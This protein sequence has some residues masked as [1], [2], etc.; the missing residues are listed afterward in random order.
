LISFVMTCRSQ[1]GNVFVI[2]KRRMLLVIMCIANSLLVHLGCQV[3]HVEPKPGTNGYPVILG[4][5]TK[6]FKFRHNVWKR[7]GDRANRVRF[8]KISRGSFR[9]ACRELSGQSCST[10]YNTSGLT[11]IATSESPMQGFQS[12]RTS[13]VEHAGRPE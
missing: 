7:R 11:R 10:T 9:T 4:E 1:L 13:L 5:K 3:I 6:F 8:S 12:G 2:L